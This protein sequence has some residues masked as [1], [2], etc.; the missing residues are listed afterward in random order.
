M[1]CITRFYPRTAIARADYPIAYCFQ[2][3][4]QDLVLKY[5]PAAMTICFEDAERPCA[6]RA[7]A[8]INRLL[9][10]GTMPF[11]CD[12]EGKN[13]SQSQ[14]GTGLSTGSTHI[15]RMSQKRVIQFPGCRCRYPT[16]STSV[17]RTTPVSIDEYLCRMRCCSYRK[18]HDS[19][20]Q[21][22][23][24]FERRRA[25]ARTL[26]VNECGRKDEEVLWGACIKWISINVI[27]ISHNLYYVKFYSKITEPIAAI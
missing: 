25:P 23:S 27:H 4:K 24:I 14:H 5:S 6:R 19:L 15:G 2:H 26:I 10:T 22:G 20:A 1:R 8:G 3:P 7:E 12:G 9:E 21:P 13:Y 17:S 18:S 16:A 11:F